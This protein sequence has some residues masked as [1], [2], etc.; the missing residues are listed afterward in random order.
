MRTKSFPFSL[1]GT[2]THRYSLS[3][4][5][6]TEKSNLAMWRG[7]RRRTEAPTHR[8]HRH[9]LMGMNLPGH[10]KPVQSLDDCRSYQLLMKWKNPPAGASHPPELQEIVTGCCFKLLGFVELVKQQ[11]GNE[12]LTS[13]N[14]K[15]IRWINVCR[16]NTD[17]VPAPFRFLFL[18]ESSKLW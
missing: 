10:S 9:L 18:L 11:Q 17:C 16:L 12:T 7:H 8:P 15:S 14:R 5:K 2:L 6:H 4:C 3:E 1:P 13:Q